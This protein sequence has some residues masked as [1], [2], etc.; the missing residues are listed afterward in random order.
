[1]A[2]K[3]GP[4]FG[5]K[6][7]EPTRVASASL[8]ESKLSCPDSVIPTVR[9]YRDDRFVQ[10]CLVST[11]QPAGLQLG[12]RHIRW[13]RVSPALTTWYPVVVVVGVNCTC[14]ANINGINTA[15]VNPVGT[16]FDMDGPASACAWLIALQL[17]QPRHGVESLQP[18]EFHLFH[19]PL[20]SG[21]VWVQ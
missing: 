17:G 19:F 10:P 20:H 3:S 9:G 8:G 13:L 11:P 12:F 7:W 15:N 14:D 2:H 5:W 18:E 4:A 16:K 21:T 6:I 1:M